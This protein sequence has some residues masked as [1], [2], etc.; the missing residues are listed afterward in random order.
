MKSNLEK[1]IEN[2]I[3]DNKDVIH[4]FGFIEFLTKTFRQFLLPSGKKID[5]LTFEKI[6]DE[7]YLNII[8]IKKDEISGQSGIVQAYEYAS[9]LIDSLFSAT[10]ISTIYLKI[11]LVGY[12]TKDL[13]LTKFL[14]FLP[15]IYTYDMNPLKGISFNQLS[16]GGTIYHKHQHIDQML[17][18]LLRN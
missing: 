18:F 12:T 2:I 5:L 10:G 14:T 3:F 6:D 9:E 4:Q 16:E 7:I 1:D 13:S 17:N 15:D 11:I 8:E